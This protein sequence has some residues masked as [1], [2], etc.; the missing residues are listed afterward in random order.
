M[1]KPIIFTDKGFNEVSSAFG[2]LD[3][4]PQK[5]VSK[6]AAKGGSVLLKA[7][8]GAVPVRTGTMKGAIIRRAEKTR[9]SGKKGYDVYFDPAY[10]EVLQKPVKQPGAAG[11]KSTGSG[12]AYY[13]A[14][15]EFGYLT[16]SKGGGL[17]YVPGYHFMRDSA[18]DSSAAVKKT[19]VDALTKEIDKEW[20]K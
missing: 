8:K 5:A 13:P 10:N 12:H 17:S 19:M 14:S 1:G 3:R 7:A 2:R 15:M 11:S 18:A 20:S 4:L 16:R 9:I 6:A